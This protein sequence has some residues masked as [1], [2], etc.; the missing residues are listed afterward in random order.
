MTRHQF[1]RREF[2]STILAG[3]AVGSS[4][5]S[6]QQKN[7]PGGIPTRPLGNTGEHLSIICLGGWDI[8]VHE[9]K[10]VSLMQEAVDNGINFFDNCWE[11]HD[12]HAEELM[13]KALKQNG[14]RD[15]VFLMTKVC[16]RTYED[17]KKH[18][19]D[20][21]TR[22]Q[23]DVIDLWQFH[24]I[25]WDDDP[26]LI[27]DREKGALRAALEAQKEGKIRYIGFTGHADPDRHLE[28]LNYDFQW[29]AVQIPLNVLDAHYRSF[30]HHVMPVCNDRNI[31]VLGMKS[32]AAQ[33]GRIVRDLGIS[34]NMARR[35]SLSLPI[36]SLVA[37]IQTREE[38]MHDIELAKDFKPL[39][40]DEVKE[41][42]A[43]AEPEAQD[44]MIERYKTGDYGCNWHHNKYA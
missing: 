4:C 31:G 37:G 34:A 1:S 9:N 17:A 11:Y 3:L 14:Y 43:I 40:E 5:I 39:T 18:L 26:E 25:K 20:S 42:L 29:D 24:A 12:G 41:L 8:A 21:L 16:G 27:M 15:K 2:L 36:T 6:K 35:Y 33:D 32:L 10:A 19:E 22:L 28:M 7:H 38:L 13:G 23:T 44:G 30:Q